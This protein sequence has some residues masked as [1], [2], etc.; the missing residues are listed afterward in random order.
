MPHLQENEKPTSLVRAVNSIRVIKGNKGVKLLS[1][2][3]H[4]GIHGDDIV[5]DM[6]LKRRIK[7]MFDG[8]R[9]SNIEGAIGAASLHTEGFALKEDSTG[10]SKS[11]TIIL[12]VSNDWLIIAVIDHN[13]RIYCYTVAGMLNRT[14]MVP[15]REIKKSSQ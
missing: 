11:T 3:L 10:V 9:L 12:K 5:F 7:Y 13:S 2:N 14:Q 15:A 8:R 4:E 1:M 6:R